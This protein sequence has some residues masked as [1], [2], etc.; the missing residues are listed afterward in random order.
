MVPDKPIYMKTENSWH[1]KKIAYLHSQI[2][3]PMG[4]KYVIV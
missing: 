3:I 2:T 1:Y 4:V